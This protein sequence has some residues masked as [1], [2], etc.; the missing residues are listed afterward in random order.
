MSADPI[1]YCLER[2]T[3]HRQFERLAS[4]LMAGTD[5]PG[6]EP[7]G[8]TGDGGRD[9]LHFHR[10][11]GTITIFAYS[12]RIDWKTKFRA[13]CKRIAEMKHAADAI[14]LVSTQEITAREKDGMRAEIHDHYGWSTEY[15]DIE[16]IRS[17]L[18]GPLKSLL[19]DHPAIFVSPWFERRGG[20][21]VTH[22]QHDLIL[23][24]H[25]ATDRAFASW[26]F[27]KLSSAGYT[28][29]CHGLAPL[30]GENADASIRTLIKQRAAYYLPI[31]SSSSAS[32]P[33]LRGRIAIATSTIDRTLPCWISDLSDQDF[34]SKLTAIVPARFDN[35]WSIGLA[36][37]AQQL[38]RSGVAKPLAADLGRRIALG[39]YQ[40]EPLLL[41]KP[42][43]VY[44]N[45]FPVKI[46]EIILPYE[47]SNEGI[48][49]DPELDHRWAHVR[50]GK[51]LFAFSSAPDNLPL[52]DVHPGRYPWRRYPYRC[53][54]KSENLVK[55][56][57][58][59]SLFVACFEA[60]FQW[61]DE[62]YA[63]YLD[64]KIRQR[65][66]YQHVDGDYTH[67]TFTGERSWGSGERKSKF[68][69]QLGPVFRI[70]F[71]EEGAVWVTVRL[72]VRVTDHEG[73]PLSVRMIPSRRKRVTKSW[74][75]RQWLQRTLGMM[76]FIA[77]KGADIN[78][79]I[80]I[81]DG[82]QKVAVGV[83]P[84]SWECPVSIDVEALDRVGDFQAELAA[85][86]EIP[87]DE[88][89][90]EEGADG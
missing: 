23:I 25:L 12:V 19:S 37:L 78:G 53:D 84:L 77:G 73:H 60:G 6:I 34:D 56:L 63:F 66:G 31:L 55:M 86:R 35:S 62:N 16:R 18:T 17:L 43:R 10:G 26:L 57:V 28:V 24:D 52:A 4:D 83:A 40:T 14:V 46:P 81:G 39:A 8:G 87:G 30:A 27:G 41:L 69:Y 42:E 45:V 2:L 11:K 85:A 61:C 65:H 80:T 70:T 48:E 22:E 7:L 74:W 59:R 89:S 13:D 54:V 20:E 33:D 5:Y 75:N 21:L 76:Q 58:K 36:S 72:Y 9:A 38:D 32:N 49:L 82:L 44:A 15:Y 64:E 90:P 1:I 79:H 51:Y 50:R 47:L 67:V 3:D 68:R 29:W 71:D 88:F